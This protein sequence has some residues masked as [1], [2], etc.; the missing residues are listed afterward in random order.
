M[1]LVTGATGFI[2]RHAVRSLLDK[3]SAV[4]IL[5]MESE[6]ELAKA[7]P[8]VEIVVGGLDNETAL[9]KA[10]A[11]ADAVIHL[12]SKNI[13]RDGT[14]FQQINVEG[15]R[16]LCD[17]A[18]RAGVNRFVYLST[19]GVYGHRRLSNANE[20]TPVRPDTDFSRSKAEAERIVLSRHEAGKFQ[21]VILRHRFVY[22]EGDLHVIPRM[23]R[24]AQMHPILISQGRARISL[25]LVDEL[26]EILFRFAL[27][28]VALDPSPVYHVTDGAPLSYR[29][30]IHTL[31]EAYGLKPPA[32]SVPFGLL[33]YP[34][35][36]KEILTG[37]DPEST[38]SSLS[39]IRLKL[40]G[41][42][43]SFSNAKLLQTF[44]DLKLT[45]F[46]SVFPKLKDYY[47]R[48]VEKP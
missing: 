45:P 33:Y 15:T 11:G 40:V 6:R 26:A 37:T 30:L 23:I 21:G 38:K 48:Y 27:E 14:G 13:N 20:S 43:N 17:A 32:R 9:N 35:R 41:L 10:V 34:I 39:S 12:A 25:I 47:E 1:I 4:R 29:D 3:G 24:A 16:K 19:V 28:H 7:F 36:L 31:C 44:P 2:G 46:A 18:V 5:L 42:D 8:K 22:G